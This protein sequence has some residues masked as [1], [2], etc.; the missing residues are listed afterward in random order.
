MASLP[1]SLTAA[2]GLHR[3]W[4]EL[5]FIERLLHALS[6]VSTATLTGRDDFYHCLVTEAEK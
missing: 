5:V 1:Q 3:K 6:D 2:S 4:D